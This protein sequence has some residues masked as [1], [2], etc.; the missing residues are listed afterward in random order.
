MREV[1]LQLSRLTSSFLL[2]RKCA[3]S[4]ALKRGGAQ[5]ISRPIKL[6]STFE[7]EM[8]THSY[9][10]AEMCPVSRV[11]TGL[12]DCVSIRSETDMYSSRC[13]VAARSLCA[14][15]LSCLVASVYSASWPQCLQRLRIY[16]SYLRSCK[17]ST[18]SCSRLLR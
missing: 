5:I 8:H 17:R 10:G 14:D 18:S 1:T 13:R 11:E 9:N 4:T 6:D 12:T 7:P 16:T 3:G 15:W 2:D